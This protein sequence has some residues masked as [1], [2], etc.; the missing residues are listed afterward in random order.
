MSFHRDDQGSH[1]QLPHTSGLHASQLGRASLC[2]EA[3]CYMGQ[4][5]QQRLFLATVGVSN[6][7]GAT[8][9]AFCSA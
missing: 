3:T 2:F 4:N 1:S 7:K 8:V 5:I 9:W 6:M